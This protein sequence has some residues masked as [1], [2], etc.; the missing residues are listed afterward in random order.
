MSKLRI[1]LPFE[2]KNGFKN[3]C[4]S[5][6]WKYLSVPCQWWSLQTPG[7][8]WWHL[9]SSHRSGPPLTQCWM[10]PPA[11]LQASS[12]H[13]QS[14]HI[15]LI[16]GI[17]LQMHGKRNR[18]RNIHWL[19][20]LWWPKL[21]EF[22]LV[23]ENKTPCFPCIFPCVLSVLPVNFSYKIT[24]ILNSNVT[25]SISHNFFCNYLLGI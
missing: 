11:A 24:T 23:F 20:P 12:G 14:T 7:S 8:S 2:A 1:I 16:H 18:A 13:L 6:P 3:I 25:S 17:L 21:L 10:G 19:S 4:E 5:R 9:K 15:K 22:L